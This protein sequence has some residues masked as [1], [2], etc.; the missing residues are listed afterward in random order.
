MFAFFIPRMGRGTVLCAGLKWPPKLDG[1]C[2]GSRS[3]TRLPDRA[4]AFDGRT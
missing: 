2:T 3:S 1:R 4:R